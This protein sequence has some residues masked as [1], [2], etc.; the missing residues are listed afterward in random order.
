MVFFFQD[1]ELDTLDSEDEQEAGAGTG[2]IAFDGE[3]PVRV[4]R[5][6]LVGRPASIAAEEYVGRHKK[7]LEQHFNLS[8][9]DWTSN[10]LQPARAEAVTG[11]EDLASTSLDPE[12]GESE[13]PEIAPPESLDNSLEILTDDFDSSSAC[14]SDESLSPKASWAGL[15]SEI[16]KLYSRYLDSGTEERAVVSDRA[17]RKGAKQATGAA[18]QGQSARTVN[19]AVAFES[20]SEPV[21]LTGSSAVQETLTGLEDKTLYSEAVRAAEQGESQGRQRMEAVVSGEL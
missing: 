10:A 18:Q 9:Q 11:S 2:A 20:D 19:E 5:A 14:S 3:E 17:T 8:Y 16:D 4:P 21:G 7:N 15:A 1:R 13:Q 6:H 12:V